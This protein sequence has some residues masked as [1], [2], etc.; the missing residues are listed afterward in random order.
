[1]QIQLPYNHFHNSHPW[2]K[3]LFKIDSLSTLFIWSMIS[4]YQVYCYSSTSLIMPPLL[5]CK[6]GLISGVVFGGS[7]LIRG[8]GFYWSRQ[9]TNILLSHFISGLLYLEVK[10]FVP[11]NSA[12]LSLARMY[13]PSLHNY[14]GNCVK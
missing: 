9:S 11:L 7:G 10:S 4:I 12:L 3:V 2:R 1:M 6:S 14:K 5:Q 13:F 8:V